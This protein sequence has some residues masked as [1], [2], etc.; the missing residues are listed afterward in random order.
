MNRIL[1]AATAATLLLAGTAL[2]A[3]PAERCQSGKNKEAGKYLEC[4]QKAEA[5]FA[6]TGQAAARTVAIQKC[7]AKYRK[8]WPVIEGKAAGSCPSTGDQ[9]PV[10]QH[11]DTASADVAAAL[12]GGALA[13]HGHRL[14]TGQTQCRNAQGQPVSCTGT[15]QD[16]EL[17]KG[18]DRGYVDNGDGTITDTRTGL[19][20]EKLSDDGT[21]HDKD[22]EYLWTEALS[23]KVA[24][25]NQA[26]F[27]GQTDWRLP[28]VNELQT[29]ANY[30]V[31]IPAVSPAFHTGCVPGCNVLTCSCTRSSAY[32]SSTAVAANPRLAWTVSAFGM[33]DP[34]TK[35]AA[36][37]SVRAVRGGS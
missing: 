6:L 12:A 24:Q 27:A 33:I 19:V 30:G 1:W 16:G 23:G 29:L 14:E 35:G 25:L 28:S 37:R 31:G 8:S 22:W 18:V 17:Q 2:A 15:G 20:W 26:A 4:L 5:K 13:D 36:H 3:T 21:I 34:F 10:A 11:L 32:W 7:S 9:T